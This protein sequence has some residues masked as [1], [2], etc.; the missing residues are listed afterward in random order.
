MKYCSACGAAVSRQWVDLDRRERDVCLSCNTIHYQNPRIIVSCIVVFEDRL[1]MCRRSQEPARGEWAIPAGFLECGETLEQGAARETY[2]ETGVIV[3]PSRL[4][5]SAILN[6]TA[7]DQ[8]MITFRAEMKT[9]PTVRPGA[10]CLE[11]AFVSESEIADLEFAWRRSWGSVPERVFNELRS[12]D[13]S[14]RL[15]S[16]GSNHGAGFTE[17]DYKIQRR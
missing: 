10:E 9:L 1:L 7:I 15:I 5:L 16:I 3:D 2:E 11:A 13:F 14:I 8:V 4:D 12:R 17:R 6:I